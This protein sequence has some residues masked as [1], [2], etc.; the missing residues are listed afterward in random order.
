MFTAFL[1]FG[2]VFAFALGME[3][4]LIILRSYAN[5]LSTREMIEKLGILSTVIT[6]NL[7]SN[8]A[9]SFGENTIPG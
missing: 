3:V 5:C 9:I 4:T 7:S 2:A 8:N 6:D 1:I